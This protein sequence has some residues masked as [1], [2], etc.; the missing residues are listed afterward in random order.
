MTARF[1]RLGALAALLSTFTFAC[2]ATPVPTGS[3]EDDVNGDSDPADETDGDEDKK[4]PSPTPT[5]TSN[6]TPAPTPAASTPPATESKPATE[7]PNNRTCQTARDMGEVAGDDGASAVQATGA[8]SD[9]LKVR[10]KESKS[11]VLGDEMKFTATL[12]SPTAADDFDLVV[13]MNADKD[14][15]ECTAVTGKSEKTGTEPDVVKASWGEGW[16]GNRDDDS[17]T[18]I[19]EVKKKTPGCSATPWTLQV[20]G[21]F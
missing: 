18:V 21:N 13:H 10:V 4:T 20:Q 7:A 19:L 5:S 2:A 9:W 16:T 17:R 1:A 3:N 6:P 11:S 12:R 8:C 15:V 14:Q